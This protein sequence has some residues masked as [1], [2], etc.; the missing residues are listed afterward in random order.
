MSEAPPIAGEAARW[1]L[2]TPSARAGAIAVI[3]LNGDIGGAL[4]KLGIRGVEP[5]ELALRELGGVDRGLVARA[6]AESAFLMPHGGAEVVRRLCDALT[7]AG[8]PRGADD[9]PE[10]RFP[11][12]RSALEARVLEALARAASPMAVDLLLDQPRRW[13][14]W[15]KAEPDASTPAPHEEH[16]ALLRRLIVPPVVV[17]VG[18]PNIGKST[19]LNR[20]AG[21]SVVA[22]ADEP[23]T[24]RDHVGAMID[25][26][27]LVLTYVDTPG[28]RPDARAPERDAASVI[29]GL[30][31]SADLVLLLGDRDSPPPEG[32]PARRALRIALRSDLG[33][34]AWPHDLAV[35]AVSRD[36]LGAM[37][38]ALREALVP[39]WAL[40]S[41]LPWRFW[42]TPGAT[43]SPGT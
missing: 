39:G 23:G 25:A 2:C 7:R 19:L 5:G 37:V 36:G 12:A 33:P 14:A 41:T 20:L 3:Q 24:T 13:A 32:L 38:G 11:E 34:A 35:S 43:L 15:G 1:R 29:P 8:M 28:M 16:S 17:A 31:E 4:G 6:G 10:A 21:R 26:A 22:V 9:T 40:S 42:E 27:G 30:V 18:G